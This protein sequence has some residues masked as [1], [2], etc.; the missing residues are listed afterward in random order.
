[1]PNSARWT[2]AAG[3]PRQDGREQWELLQT[4]PNTF[5]ML[6]SD[7]PLSP[8]TTVLL[9]SSWLSLTSSRKGGREKET[10]GP[11]RGRKSERWNKKKLPLL[12][13]KPGLPATPCSLLSPPPILIIKNHKT[14]IEHLLGPE[15]KMKRKEIQEIVLTCDFD[16]EKLSKQHH[17]GH[18]GLSAEEKEKVN[19]QP[20]QGLC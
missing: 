4:R 17:R 8:V 6:L 5:T 1:M 2:L 20:A 7:I 10:S 19:L 14:R 18:P 12:T 9:E 11:K 15:H 16:A 3:E 13:P